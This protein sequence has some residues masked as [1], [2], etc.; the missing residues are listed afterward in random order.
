MSKFYKIVAE[1]FIVSGNFQIPEIYKKFNGQLYCIKLCCGQ[2]GAP[3][4]YIVYKRA[5]DLRWVGSH[6]PT[7]P[8]PNGSALLCYY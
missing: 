8:P 6:S 3:V 7:H 4:A 2:L 5:S 1:T